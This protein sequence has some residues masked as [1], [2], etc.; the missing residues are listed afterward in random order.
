MGIIGPWLVVQLFPYIYIIQADNDD[1][2]LDLTKLVVQCIPYLHAL[3]V[4]HAYRFRAAAVDRFK[5]L[6]NSIL[7]IHTT[8]PVR[9]IA[10]EKNYHNAHTYT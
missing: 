4:T 1:W 7:E 5:Q 9:I 8:F 3:L 10:Y 2:F 6:R